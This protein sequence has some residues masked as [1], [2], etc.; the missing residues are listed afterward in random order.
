MRLSLRSL[1]RRWAARMVTV[2][3]MAA[4][5]AGW[6]E[7][8]VIEAQGQIRTLDFA[9]GRLV[10]SGIRYRIAE[11]AAISVRGS[12]GALTMLRPGMKVDFVYRRH[13]GEDLEIT[14]LEQLPDDWSIEEF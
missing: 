8:P 9:A 13:T 7:P 14:T 11:D 5:A 3:L 4:A 2:L 12:Y 6:A 1:A 10:I